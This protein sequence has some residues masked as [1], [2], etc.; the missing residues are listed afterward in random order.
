M[1]TRIQIY[2][3]KFKQIECNLI[4]LKRLS[5]LTITETD[6]T[7]EGEKG[8]TFPLNFIYLKT[9]F[10]NIGQSHV[11]QASIHI[12]QKLNL[13]KCFTSVIIV[14]IRPIECIILGEKNKH[15]SPHPNNENQVGKDISL[16]QLPTSP[17]K[18]NVGLNEPSTSTKFSP[19]PQV[20]EVMEGTKR[21][22]GSG[23]S[24]EVSNEKDDVC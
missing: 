13:T 11:K 5:T 22:H 21:P 15:E 1:Q 23:D 4:R 8:Q 17:T 19:T 24:K 10:L 20:N 6:L 12:I 14:I 7:L 3:N 18:M 2:S 16:E 9:T